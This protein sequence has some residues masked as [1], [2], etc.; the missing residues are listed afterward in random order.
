MTSAAKAPLVSIIVPNYNY[1]RYLKERMDSIFSQTMTDYEIILLDDA[2]TDGSQKILEEY[3]RD[4]R[5]VSLTINDSNTGLPFFQWKKGIDM[6]RGKY[7]WIAESDD[8]CAPEF[9]A[10]CVSEL[11]KN[12]NAVIAFTGSNTIDENGDPGE[13]D[14][15]QWYE[16]KFISRFGKAVSFNGERYVTHNMAWKN[17]VYNASGTVF[18]RDA[19]AACKHLDVC[20]KM[21]NA[22]DWYFWTVLMQHGDVIE[23]YSK[24]NNFRR[25]TGSQTA[26][27]IVNGAINGNIYL[28]DMTI[29]KFITSEF[30]MNF[31]R[32]ILIKGNLYKALVRSDVTPT[33][34]KELLNTA[35][36]ELHMSKATYVID[37][38][39]KFF[40]NFIPGIISMKNDRL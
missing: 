3:A 9:L 5:V 16:K 17:Y 18:R 22:G 36:K 13:L 31:L 27:G 37:R 4:P 39:N 35:K 6:A 1:A 11:E 38:I 28:E 19:V 32:K 33:Q 21:K 14:Y 40:W 10:S 30:K 29:R 8:S 12:P 25:H 20:F 15:D 7:V 24:L 26:K 34:K 23:I 2:S